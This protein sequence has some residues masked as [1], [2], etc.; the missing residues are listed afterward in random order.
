MLTI[1]DAVGGFL[2][3]IFSYYINAGALTMPFFEKMSNG[4]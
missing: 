3:P 4:I 1:F 2:P